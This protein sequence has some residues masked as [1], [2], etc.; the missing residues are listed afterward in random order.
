MLCCDSRAFVCYRKPI[1]DSVDRYE[2]NSDIS[3]GCIIVHGM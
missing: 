1:I 3:I 2:K